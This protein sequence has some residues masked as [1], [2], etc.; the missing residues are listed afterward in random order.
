VQ[1]ML[2]C[3]VE[4]EGGP[5][6]PSIVEPSAD[7]LNPDRQSFVAE[8]GVTEATGCSEMLNGKQNGLCAVPPGGPR[9]L[10][11]LGRDGYGRRQ[12]V[13]EPVERC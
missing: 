9:Q 2:G 12:Q 7:N 3:G 4:G 5:Q 10:R 1:V 8:A 11:R 13:I 6:H